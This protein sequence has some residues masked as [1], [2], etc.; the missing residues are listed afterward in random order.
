MATRRTT[1]RRP[2]HL[3]LDDVRDCALAQGT[4]FRQ[5]DILLVQ[6][7]WTTR[8]YRS[9]D[10][11]RRLR[12]SGKRGYAGL[13]QGDHILEWLWD[14]HFAAV[15]SDA[16]A[17]ESWPCQLGATHLHE[18]FL[19][20]WGISIGEIFDLEALTKHCERTR[21]WNFLLSQLALEP[22]GRCGHHGKCWCDLL[23][24]ACTEA[25]SC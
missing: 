5:G 11:E 12:V 9:T 22:M 24:V 14:N 1:L 8:N 23:S 13:E 3:T 2:R 19:G 18:N 7:G 10:E 25:S 16:P 4:R 6:V 15:A 17:L 20:L 21:R